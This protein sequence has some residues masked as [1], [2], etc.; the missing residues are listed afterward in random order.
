L[1]SQLCD[2]A[3]R[4]LWQIRQGANISEQNK[5]ITIENVNFVV[6]QINDI[7]SLNEIDLL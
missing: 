5:Q 7:N 3:T 1:I 6:E 4:D 2:A